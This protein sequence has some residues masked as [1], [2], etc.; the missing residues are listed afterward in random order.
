LSVSSARA[1]T[2]NV[3]D[4]TA[5]GPADVVNKKT[6]INLPNDD[7]IIQCALM[8]LPGSDQTQIIAKSIVIDGPNG[9]SVSS[10]GKGGNATLLQATGDITIDGASVVAADS[11]G[12]AV[13]NAGGNILA[14]AGSHLEAGDDVIVKCTGALCTV[15]IAQSTIVANRINV[16]GN[17]D[18]TVDPSSVLTT[19]CPRDEIKIVSNFGDVLLGG[20][21]V[22]GLG[23]ICCNAVQAI[24]SVSPNDPACPFAGG[25]T[26]ELNDLQELSAFCADCQQEPN[27]LQTCVEGNVIILAPNGDIDLS[28]LIILV[29]ESITITALGEINMTN[30][31][32]K[33]CGKKTGVIV[34]T[35]ATCT[36]QNATIQDDV[37]E[38]GPTLN[39][40]QSGVPALLG[41]CP[42]SP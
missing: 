32:I 1:A 8:S 20:G 4:C 36:V 13:I 33:N 17:G 14:T 22:G 41:S 2:V 23:T 40:A 25:G 19:S 42:A 34:I 39:C 27:K 35:S 28:N 29:G 15:D 18:V 5:A 26:I 31:T 11:N 16:E 9:G 21:V 12:N 6:V 38:A 37:P 7:V 30:A 10:S 3:T 24:C